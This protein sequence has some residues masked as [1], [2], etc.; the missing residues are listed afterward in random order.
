MYSCSL[1]MFTVE[2]QHSGW[3]EGMKIFFYLRVNSLN[4]SMNHFLKVFGSDIRTHFE[5]ES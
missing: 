1:Y 3:L 2:L 4:K 5:D